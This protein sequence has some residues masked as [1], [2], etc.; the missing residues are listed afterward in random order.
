MYL[1][2]PVKYKMTYRVL[3]HNNVLLLQF[4]HYMFR[5]S[6]FC[7]EDILEEC[8]CVYVYLFV[9]TFQMY[10]VKWT[11]LFYTLSVQRIF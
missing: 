8:V 2:S 7:V 3:A 9:C 11:E 6:S 10:C 5:N 4:T 1:L